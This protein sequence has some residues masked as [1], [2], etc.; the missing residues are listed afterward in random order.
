M[1][2]FLFKKIGKKIKINK[3]YSCLLND[4]FVIPCLFNQYEIYHWFEDRI[5]SSNDPQ[6]SDI[7]RIA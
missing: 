6:T 2:F 4:K 5:R 1:I 3:S 7:S